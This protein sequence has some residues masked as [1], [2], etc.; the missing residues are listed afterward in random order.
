MRSGKATFHNRA[1]LQWSGLNTQDY[2][3]SL[4]KYLGFVDFEDWYK[5]TKE[6]FQR[7]GGSRF[8]AKYGDS[9]S[10]LVRDNF[11]STTWF[12]WKFNKVPNGFWNKDTE[13]E[14]F[15]WLGKELR[16]K[17]LDDWYTI[18]KEEI[19]THGGR[20]LLNRYGSSPWRA[21]CANFPSKRWLPWKFSTV[22]KGFWEDLNNQ[23]DLI[24]RITDC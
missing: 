5:V 17:N 21:I 14:F 19:H 13:R 18:T 9:P 8:L 4:G 11:R 15:D 22:C 16:Y 7:N 23:V 10:R 1:S 3:Q 2:L 6:D 24:I 20:G 12:L